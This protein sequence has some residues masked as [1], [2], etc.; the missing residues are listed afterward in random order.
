MAFFK[1][2]FPGRTGDM[3]RYEVILALQKGDHAKVSELFRKN[4]SPEI[5]PEYWNFASSAEREED[6]RF[7]SRDKRYPPFCQALL[8]IKKKERNSACDLLEKA[9]AQGNQA[10]LFFAART[11]AE[12]GRNKAAEA[13]AV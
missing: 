5:L 6:L 10:L 12:N 7:L 11:L 2:K 4:F 8:K 3:L 1:K 13:N 9:D